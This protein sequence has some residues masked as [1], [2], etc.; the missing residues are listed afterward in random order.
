MAKKVDLTKRRGATGTTISSGVIIGEDYNPK[1]RDNQAIRVWDEMS[2]D[3]TVNAALDVIKEP[4][5][6]ADYEIDPA[7]EDKRDEEIAEFARECLF[8]I[9][10][11]DQFMD[12][13]LT[14]LEYGHDV[15]E[16]IFEPR[17]VLGVRRVA[18][19]G[20]EY[21]KQT[22]ITRW[23]MNDM[24]TPGISQ[25]T[26]DGK[27]YE[28]PAE[29]LVRF[30][31]RQR[32][33]NY[34]G[35]SLLRPAYKHWFMKDLL[36]RYD[37]LANQKQ[38]VGVLDVT[39]PKNAT[40][41]DRAAIRKAARNVRADPE[42]YIEHPEEYVLQFLDMK[43]N[44]HRSVEPSI[45]HHDR[46]IMKNVLAQFLEIGAAGSSGTR[47]VGQDQGRILE[48]KIKNIAKSIVY[49][50]QN[51]V[52]KTLVDLNF[53]NVKNYPKLRVSNISDEDITILSDAVS[54]FVTAGVI[55]PRG[56][57]E[58]TTRKM[59]GWPELSQEE[60]DEID[61]TKGIAPEDDPSSGDGAAS[62]K[63]DPTAVAVADVKAGA[64]LKAARELKSALNEKLYG[65]T[66][67]KDQAA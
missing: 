3:A 24:V 1:L 46:Q 51:S 61:Y 45:N 40:E 27:S 7:S 13:A 12:E 25:T 33:D 41:K 36:Y 47:N 18:L 32:G 28:I 31:Y 16:M 52:I 34:V 8:E 48:K 9:V 17:D 66:G 60:L 30:T 23:A 21:R 56:E 65:T 19:V 37:M 50:I 14:Y 10:G 55:H 35:K 20:L 63:A 58:K 39:V 29:K 43:A 5:K 67:L 54:K 22:T 15:H 44:T 11:W 4:L 2:N 26:G 57:D 64:A 53:T 59:I 62:S 49:V 6:G 38:A 42:S